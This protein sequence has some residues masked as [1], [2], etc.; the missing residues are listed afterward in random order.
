MRLLY[1]EN[2]SPRLPERLTDAFPDSRHVRDA[3]LLGH[4]DTDIWHYARRHGFLLVSKD[5]DFRQMSFLHGSPPKVIRLHVGNAPT[6][7]IADLLRARRDRIESFVND[8]E[9][10]LLIV[11][12]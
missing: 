4:G 5:N 3:G 6:R 7:D 10:A 8:P 1:D 12:A 11:E 9:S 2:L